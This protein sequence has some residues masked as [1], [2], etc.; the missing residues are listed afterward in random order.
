MPRKHLGSKHPPLVQTEP[1]N[2]I[3]YELHLL[4]SVGDILSGTSFYRQTV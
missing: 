2:I 1:K 4:L 3:L